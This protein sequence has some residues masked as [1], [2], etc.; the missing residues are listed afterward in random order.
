MSKAIKHTREFMREAVKLAQSSDKPIVNTAN[1]LGINPKTLY[2][3]VSESMKN[4]PSNK[5]S[6]S[7]SA[8][9]SKHHYQ[10]LAL[11]NQRLKKELK[12]AE[13]ERDILKKAAAYF[14]SQE[15]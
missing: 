1:K 9:A 7:T 11:E 14:A 2:R 3:W 5:S 15:L 8:A 12:R 6:N 10:E 4:K 13:M